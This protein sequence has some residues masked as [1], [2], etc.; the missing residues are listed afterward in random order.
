M[1]VPSLTVGQNCWHSQRWI[2][3]E[4]CTSKLRWEKF[5]SLGWSQV[6]QLGIFLLFKMPLMP[7]LLWPPVPVPPMLLKSPFDLVSPPY[8]NAFLMGLLDP[9]FLDSIVS[10]D[11]LKR[12]GRVG[13]WS[14]EKA[15]FSLFSTSFWF[16]K[17]SQH[18]DPRG[19]WVCNLLFTSI[20][21]MVLKC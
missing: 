16:Y 10:V 7:P 1:W 15:L 18:L 12:R 4:K 9:P 19:A 8:L 13:G 5:C 6:S 21:Y 2:Q 14:P 3:N 20:T 11:S 17:S